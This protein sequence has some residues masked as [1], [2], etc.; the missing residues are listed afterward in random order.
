[1]AKRA[2]DLTRRQGRKSPREA[3]LILCEGETEVSYF[4]QLKEY[5]RDALT[6][7]V[8]IDK[9][10]SSPITMMKTAIRK[11]RDQRYDKVFC[12]FD[13]DDVRQVEDAQK[14]ARR[15]T[16]IQVVISNPC[17]ELWFILHFDYTS[18]PYQDC[19][20]AKSHLTEHWW[21]GYQSGG[22]NDFSILMPYLKDAIHHAERLAVE[23]SGDPRTEI[24]TLI[25]G[26]FCS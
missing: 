10:H 26:I 24:H 14:I 23:C 7:A 20:E 15:Q 13:G 21:P 3:I 19:A 25:N 6:V 12:V 17:I 5:C 18:R 1:M 16:R 2:M 4:K 22:Q 11:L 9:D 8:H